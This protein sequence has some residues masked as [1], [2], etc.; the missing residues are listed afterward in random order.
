MQVQHGKKP[1]KHGKQKGN[2]KTL[3]KRMMIT[4]TLE[5]YESLYISFTSPLFKL[6]RGYWSMIKQPWKFFGNLHAAIG[7][8]KLKVP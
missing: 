8:Y 3:H 2:F 6:N 1:G 4:C 5:K 7:M